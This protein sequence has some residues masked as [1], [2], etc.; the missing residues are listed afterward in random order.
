M[1]R[2]FDMAAWER[3]YRADLPTASA[4]LLHRPELIGRR[5]I[6]SISMATRTDIGALEVL[7]LPIGGVPT[8][9]DPFLRFGWYFVPEARAQAAGQ[10]RAWDCQGLLSVVPGQITDGAA[11]LRMLRAIGTHFD[12]QKVVYD[13][14][15]CGWLGECL[16]QGLYP[17]SQNPSRVASF[18]RPMLILSILIAQRKI[19]HGDCPVMHWQMGN[20]IGAATAPFGQPRAVFPRKASVDELIDSPVA[21]IAALGEAWNLLDLVHRS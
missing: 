12:L 7:V 21:L 17:I 1:I 4:D 5:A 3:C 8:V 15:S 10:Y 14:F 11:V 2:Y 16:A 20:V 19:R 13:P 6:A 18:D 9:D